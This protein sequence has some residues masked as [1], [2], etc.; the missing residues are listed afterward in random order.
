MRVMDQEISL[1]LGRI[2][3]MLEQLLQH[4]GVSVDERP[5]RKKGDPS[6]AD[7]VMEAERIAEIYKTSGREAMKAAM[8]ERNEKARQRMKSKGRAVSGGRR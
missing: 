8:K 5:K 3:S 1:W 6:G 4:G 7:I 2:E